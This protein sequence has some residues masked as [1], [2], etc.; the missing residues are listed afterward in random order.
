MVLSTILFF[1]NNRG[2]SNPDLPGFK[3]LEGLWFFP[4]FYSSLTTGD[5][6]IQ[7]FQVL[8]TWKV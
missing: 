5:A 6:A 1:A 7:T 8:K 2:R 4:P 3:N